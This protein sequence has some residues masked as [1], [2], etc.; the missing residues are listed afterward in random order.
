MLDIFNIK[1]KPHAIVFS[2]NGLI[3][4][5]SYIKKYIKSILNDSKYDEKINSLTYIDL[6]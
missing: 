1:N 4:I 5:N 3:D 2:Y 6:F